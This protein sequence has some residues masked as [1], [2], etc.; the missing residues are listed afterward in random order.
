MTCSS[1]AVSAAGTGWPLRG[2]DPT[3][4]HPGQPEPPDD[5]IRAHR[6]P[7]QRVLVDNLILG[8]IVGGV[9]GGR[10]RVRVAGAGPDGLAQTSHYGD[11]ASRRLPPH[12]P[13][14]KRNPR[15]ESAQKSDAP[16]GESAGAYTRTPPTPFTP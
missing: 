2:S 9:R 15:R 16:E 7:C 5:R 8:G 6:R 13:G 4:I 12:Q 3:A 10:A 1:G 14:P 11:P